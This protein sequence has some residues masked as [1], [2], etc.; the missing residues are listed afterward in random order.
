MIRALFEFDIKYLFILIFSDVY[1]IPLRFRSYAHL[2]FCERTVPN[3]PEPCITTW[4]ITNPEDKGTF[5]VS[6]VQRK[7]P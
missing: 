6:K 4:W 1:V 7:K 5:F 3:N 2:P